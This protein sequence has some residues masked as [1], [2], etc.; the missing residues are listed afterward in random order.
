MDTKI[1]IIF[2]SFF[3]SFSN[4]LEEIVNYLNVTKIE[5]LDDA[6]NK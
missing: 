3:I 1:F 5:P 2:L 6:C 4:C